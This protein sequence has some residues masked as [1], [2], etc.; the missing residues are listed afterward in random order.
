MADMDM[1]NLSDEQ[2][3][4]LLEKYSQED[5]RRAAAGKALEAEADQYY[6]VADRVASSPGRSER[7]FD[8]A[9]LAAL[10]PGPLTDMSAEE[11]LPKA[12]PVEGLNPPGLTDMTQPSEFI[13]AALD[14]EVSKKLATS[15]GRAQS[16]PDARMSAAE[17][18]FA[19]VKKD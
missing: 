3:K 17:K 2:L 13:D 12:S 4:A 15:P 16:L 14:E 19:R 6:D 8:K 11:P 1:D 7:E 5:A 10:K 18:A 9:D